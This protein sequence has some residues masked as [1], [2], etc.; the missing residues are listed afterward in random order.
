M[1]F[2]DRLR[3]AF[4]QAD[5]SIKEERL[6]YVAA[7]DRGK[8]L[9][10][11][12]FATVAAAAA[13]LVGGGLA[14]ASVI[15]G[16][17][18]PIAPVGPEETETNF[19]ED[20]TPPPPGARGDCSAAKDAHDVGAQPEVPQP[21]LGVRMRIVEEAWACDFEGL[22]ELA[23]TPFNFDNSD[24]TEGASDYWRGLEE[25]KDPITKVLV[26]LLDTEPAEVE[27]V[28]GVTY[29]WPAAAASDEPTEEQWAEVER[30]FDGIYIPEYI[31]NLRELGFY[32]GNRIEI[33]EDGEWTTF[34]LG[35][36]ASA[37]PEEQAPP[38]RS[39][40]GF[41]PGETGTACSG[42]QDAHTGYTQPDLP[43]VVNGVR[44][45]IIVRT[46]GC[47]YE[48]LEEIAMF[49]D[50][51]RFE[52]TYDA[53]GVPP[54]LFWKNLEESGEPILAGLVEALESTPEMRVYNSRGWPPSYVWRASG[55]EVRIA[56]DG[57]WWAF[58]T[59]P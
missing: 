32:N 15:S 31:D 40:G 41:S 52:Y 36:S 59:A 26:R 13:L 18:A 51:P 5:R 47:D 25:D 33:T 22:E 58:V 38:A 57:D 45:D 39:G 35:V 1:E 24:R 37:A 27:T 4:K 28:A 44:Q 34:A 43:E 23:G 48:G 46:W 17:E 54:S 2:E 49:D 3:R 20:P 11:T 55:Y 53:V 12:R 9:R 21:V 10:I 16:G 19:T 29:V 6:E 42:A 8:R 14:G 50:D 30:A 7:L 56:E